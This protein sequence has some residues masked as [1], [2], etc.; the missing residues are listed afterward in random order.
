MLRR[1]EKRGYLEHRVEGKVFVFRATVRRPSV[2]ARAVQHIIDRFW[3]GSVEQ[4]LTG[5]VDERL[6][7]AAELR[8]LARKVGNKK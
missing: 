3:A 8:R 1:L 7:S 6:L 2:A 4:F 5:M